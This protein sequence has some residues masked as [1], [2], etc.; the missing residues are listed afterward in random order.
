MT[1]NVFLL[2]CL[3]A[4]TSSTK[5]SAVCKDIVEDSSRIYD[6]EEVVIVD[7]PK[8]NLRL[9]QQPLSSTTFGQ[10]Q[11]HLLNVGSLHQLSAFVPSFAMPNYGSRYTSS[12]YIRGIGSRVYSP[13]MGI[14]LDGMPIQSKSALNFHIYD[15]ERIDILRGPQSTLYGTNTEGGLIRL[16]T[17]NPFNYQGTDIKLSIGTKFKR[18]FEAVLHK[19][20]SDNFAYSLAAFYSGENGSFKNKF[21]G[22]YASLIN[23]FGS[24]AKLLWR[25]NTN[26]NFML[27][28]DYQNTD[29][30]AAPYGLFLTSEQIAQAPITS[31]LFGLKPGTQAPNQNRQSSYKRHLLNTGFGIKYTA[32]QFEINSMMTWQF[33]KDRMLMDV[34]YL[35]KDYLLLQ[36]KQKQNA[37]TQELTIKNTTPATWNWTFGAIATHQWLRTE[38]PVVFGNDM[39]KHL[40]Q[41]I[42]QYAYNGILKSM[43]AGIAQKLIQNGMSPEQAQLAALVTARTMI[44]AAGGCNITI[45]MSP[46]PGTFQMPSTNLGIFHESNIALTRRLTATIGLRYD[47]SRIEIDYATSARAILNEQVMGVT[48]T[49]TITSILR[50][51]ESTRFKH[52]LPKAGL[53]YKLPNQSNIYF[54]CAKGYRAGGYN[55][56]MFT[57]ILQSELSAATQTARQDINIAHTPEQYRALAETITYKPETSWNYEIGAHLNTKNKQLHVDLAAYYARIRNQQISVM[58]SNYGFGRQTTNA[59][60]SN[61]FGIETQLRGNALDGKMNYAFSYAFA[62]AQFTRTNASI[63]EP[64]HN[65][66]TPFIPRHT[67]GTMVD[68]LIKVDPAALINPTAKIHLRTLTVGLNLSA[69]GPIYWDMAN[70]IRQNFY[71]LLGAHADANFGPLHLN[72]WIRNLTDTRHNTFA[73]Q[74]SATGTRLTFAQQGHPFQLGLDIMYHF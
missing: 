8:E 25:T 58:A 74:S 73:I 17:R 10:N 64:Y 11:L 26:W 55:I 57:D 6:I 59:L 61:T 29:Q 56:Q 39:N 52:I 62:R 46:I 72:L 27:T 36:Q 45:N 9:R 65:K 48:L 35:P 32:P 15:V 49:P 20:Q 3:L 16:Y 71:A 63:T 50:S 51:N 53:L 5:M 21:N 37:L 69:N 47:I 13:A 67:L 1:R 41:L 42:T 30:N 31:P 66:Q 70:T 33:L 22:E 23:E 4:L 60:R 43:A 38:S 44:Q 2:S 40:S 54:T 18:E 24:R 19:K 34:D 12:I 68:Y 7:Q 14:Y 28:S